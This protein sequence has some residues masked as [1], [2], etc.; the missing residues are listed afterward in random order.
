MPDYRPLFNTRFFAR[1]QIRF[2]AVFVR[3]ISFDLNKAFVS[4]PHDIICEKLKAMNLNSYVI[5]WI[6]DF[7]ID[8]KQRVV[9]DGVEPEY[10]DIIRGCHKV[11]LHFR[12]L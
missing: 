11:R 8:R 10:V 9:V 5:Y 2:H 12:S 3:I 6:I 4:V 7:L 1:F